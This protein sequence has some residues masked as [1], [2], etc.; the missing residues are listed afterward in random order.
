MNAPFRPP[1]SSPRR[2]EALAFMIE[3]IVRNG[4]CP[5]FDEI[6]DAMSPQVKKSRVREL[7]GQLVK[8]GIIE[9]VPGKKRSFRVRDVTRSRMLLDD[10]L[11]KLGWSV[12]VPLG[13]LS[14]PRP[15]EQLPMLPA[16]EHLPDV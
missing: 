14:S 4:T 1:T 15:N 6:G 11:L 2:Y 5:S 16:F 12:A 3:H 7:V 10:A 13:Q 9:R 8:E